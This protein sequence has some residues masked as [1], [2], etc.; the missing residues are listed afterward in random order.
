MAFCEQCGNI[1]ND[2]AKFCGKCG[3]QVLD[4]VAIEQQFMPSVCLKCGEQLEEGEQFCANCGTRVVSEQL[5]TS[6]PNQREQFLEKWVCSVCGYVHRGDNA[7][8]N[9]PQCCA[10]SKKFNIERI[11][12]IIEDVFSIS[13][14]GTVV[15]GIVEN[16]SIKLNE[17]VII[18]G[19]NFRKDTM[20][21]GIESFN[22]L[23]DVA[24]PGDNVGLLLTGVKKNEIKRGYCL[25]K[26]A[27]N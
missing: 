23:L 14:R 24:N 1:L 20:V 16:D 6:Y 25:I 11:V 2:G 3:T 8:D 17:K 26:K 13:F 12:F 27:K 21:T 15:T 5:E 10:P 19:D 18:S 22:K 9:C 4:S 7:P